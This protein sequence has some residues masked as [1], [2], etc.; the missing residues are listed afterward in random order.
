MLLTNGRLTVH[1][2]SDID[3]ESVSKKVVA[4]TLLT[5]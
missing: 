5:R 4:Y 3:G 2:L 1:S